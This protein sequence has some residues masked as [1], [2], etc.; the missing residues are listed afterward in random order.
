MTNTYAINTTRG[1]EFVVEAE[2]QALGL[3]PWVP[4]LLVSKKIKEKKQPVWHDRAYIPKLIFCVFPAIYWPDVVAIKDIH[5]KPFPFKQQDIDG[6][7]AGFL[8]HPKPNEHIPLLDS[9]GEPQPIKARAGLVD[10]KR[11]VEAEYADMKRL[12]ANN[13]Y[14]CQ[15]RAG[16][17]LELLGGAFE[18]LPAVFKDTIRHAHDEYAKLRANVTLFGRETTVEVDPDKVRALTA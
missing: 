13:D 2:L 4:K 14:Q 12:Q 9:D 17:A 10:F 1:K 18:G 15:Y 8:T 16:Q 6:R 5:G 11:V 3:K 7:R